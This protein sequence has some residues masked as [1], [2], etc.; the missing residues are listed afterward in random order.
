M[1]KGEYLYHFYLPFVSSK[2]CDSDVVRLTTEKP[3]IKKKSAFPKAD[4]I[5]Y[6]KALNNIFSLYI[7]I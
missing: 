3:S 6:E 4:P 5:Y 1:G 2:N 7:F